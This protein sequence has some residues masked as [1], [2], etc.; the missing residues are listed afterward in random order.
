MIAHP[1]E[2]D[3]EDPERLTQTYLEQVNVNKSFRGV[4]DFL[5]TICYLHLVPRLAREP[6]RSAGYRNDPCGD[7]QVSV[8]THSPELLQDEGIGLDEV[9]LPRP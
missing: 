4:A 3:E 7:R 6:D 8:S 9:L 1:S 2:Q 5:K